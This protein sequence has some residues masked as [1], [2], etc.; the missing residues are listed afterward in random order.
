[1]GCPCHLQ[2]ITY[3]LSTLPLLSLRPLSTLGR[4]RRE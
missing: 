4:R 1:M 2:S 3:R